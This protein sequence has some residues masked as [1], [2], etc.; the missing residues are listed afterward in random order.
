M[1]HGA[2]LEGRGMQTGKDGMV[3]I[4]ITPIRSRWPAYRIADR[5]QTSAVTAARND[6]YDA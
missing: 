4:G 3:K 6:L 1:S 2:E 5:R